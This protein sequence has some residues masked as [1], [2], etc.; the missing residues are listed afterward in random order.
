MDVGAHQTIGR[1]ALGLFLRSRLSLFPQ[2]LHGFIHVAG[3]FNQRLTANIEAC[4]GQ[5][6]EF[7]D[8]LCRYVRRLRI[9][10]H[11]SEKPFERM[12]CI[13]ENCLHKLQDH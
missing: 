10:A 4:S 7:F 8:H 11:R 2:I 9:R 13:S 3:R 6:A 1:F 12:N 5:L